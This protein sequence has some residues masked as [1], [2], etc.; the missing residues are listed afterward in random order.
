MCYLIS[1]VTATYNA[2]SCLENL[3][4]SIIL[5]KEK[6][7][8]FIIIDGN[9]NDKTLDIIRKHEQYIDYWLSEPDEGIYDAW[10]KGIKVA[11]GE[12]VMFLGADD[13]L[14]PGAISYYCNL[15]RTKDFSNFDY[16]SAHNKYVD[17]KNKLLKILGNGA[18][19]NLMRKNMTAAHVGS[20]HN[21]RNLF[22][23]VG[24]YS[25][26]YKICGDYELLLRKRDKLKSYF[27]N[28]NMAQMKVG[29]VSFTIKAINETFK[30]R[31]DHQTVS[32]L[33][34]CMLYIKDSLAYK[35]FKLRK[36]ICADI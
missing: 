8:E 31:K 13:I 34:N 3:I 7:I 15:L 27:V 21:K 30:I 32:I 14:L 5:Q 18:E 28:T 11:N 10:N 9:S 16:I 4:M 19:W 1:I 26:N 2:E 33:L 22:N 24:L 25:L 17:N 12:W 36:S 29:G 6:N 35:F 20:L 23:E